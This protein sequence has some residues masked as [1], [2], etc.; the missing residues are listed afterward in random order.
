MQWG[1]SNST[2]RTNTSKKWTLKMINKK[3]ATV[4]LILAFSITVATADEKRHHEFETDDISSLTVNMRAGTI[5]VEHND[6]DYIAVELLITEGDR[7]WFTKSVDMEEMDIEVAKRNSELELTFDHKGVNSDWIIK[8]PALAKIEING[9]AGTVEINM[10]EADIDANMGV[11]TI[12][13]Q[14]SKALF[15]D[16]EFASGVG[17]TSARGANTVETQRAFVSSDLK[18]YG[19]GDLTVRANV[20]VGSVEADLL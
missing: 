8:V 4:V 15:G 13:L 6:E 9:G 14:L 7:G 19:D 1:L 20:G 3:I 2:H 12:E 11:G 5:V 18:A 17:D 10:A 16:I